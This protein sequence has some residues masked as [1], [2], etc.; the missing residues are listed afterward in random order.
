[1]LILGEGVGSLLLGTLADRRGHK[2]SL[3]WAA[4]LFA[5]AFALAWLAPAAG[6]YYAVFALLGASYG[7][8]ITSGL[9]MVFEFAEP[10]RRPTYIGVAGTL[11]GLVSMAGPLLGAWLAGVDYGLLFAAGA[12]TSL[13]AWGAMRWGVQEPRHKLRSDSF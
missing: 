10:Q 8:Q 3:E 5:L 11:V 1:V 12:G 9:L 6:W 4:G 13:V 7:A 2:L